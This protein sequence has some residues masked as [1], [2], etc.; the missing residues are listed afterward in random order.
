MEKATIALPNHAV[1][2]CRRRAILKRRNSTEWSVE[3]LSQNQVGKKQTMQNAL[4]QGK[5]PMSIVSH[6]PKWRPINGQRGPGA[7]RTGEERAEQQEWPEDFEQ[8]RAEGK[9]LEQGWG[10]QATDGR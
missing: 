1:A 3:A 5:I 8:E 4:I 10:N 7:D 9:H 6:M 2:S